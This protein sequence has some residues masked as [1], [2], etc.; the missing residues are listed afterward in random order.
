MWWSHARAAPVVAMIAQSADY[1]L[2][3]S[4]MVLEGA[5]RALLSQS[6]AE[7]HVVVT[8]IHKTRLPH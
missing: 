3:L 2:K 5:K 4:R 8:M 1:P 7:S 6:R